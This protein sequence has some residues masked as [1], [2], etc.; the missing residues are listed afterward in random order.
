MMDARVGSMAADYPKLCPIQD[1]LFGA[2][3]GVIPQNLLTEGKM[4][5]EDPLLVLTTEDGRLGAAALFYTG[6]QKRISEI[7]GGDYYVLPSSVH[8]VL[9]MPDDGHTNARELAEMV[10]M[11]N[12][13]EVNPVERLGNKVLHFRTDLQELQVAADMDRD[14]DLG[15]ERG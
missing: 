11:I 3:N 15:K 7:V 8:E 10:Q 4:P 5:E 13:H 1:V 6:I 2:M 12:E 9:I 14:H